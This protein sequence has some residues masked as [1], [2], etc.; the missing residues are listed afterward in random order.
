[1]TILLCEN[2]TVTGTSCAMSQLFEIVITKENYIRRYVLV[3]LDDLKK[4][5][6]SVIACNMRQY[7]G[8]ASRLNFQV[9]SRRVYHLF[10]G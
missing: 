10:W 4:Y 9:W 2:F 8:Q 6:T 3:R 1:M 5:T 7:C